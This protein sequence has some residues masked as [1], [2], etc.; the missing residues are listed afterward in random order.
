MAFGHLGLG[1]SAIREAALSAEA[2][3]RAY[4]LRDRASDPERFYIAAMYDRQVTGNL[5]RELQTLTLWAQTYPR[6]PIAH[7]LLSKGRRAENGHDADFG[8]G[9]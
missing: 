6:D 2:T 7:G 8:T 5:E 1:Y 3:A 9:P 4:Q